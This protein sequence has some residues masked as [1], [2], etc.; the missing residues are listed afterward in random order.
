VITDIAKY[1]FGKGSSASEPSR[2]FILVAQKMNARSKVK[3]DRRAT[4]SGLWGLD[5]CALPERRFLPGTL[6]CHI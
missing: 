2:R 5:D 1:A 6:D 3:P 4:L